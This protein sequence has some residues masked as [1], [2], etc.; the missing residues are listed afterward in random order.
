VE[1]RGPEI[2]FESISF[3]VTSDLELITEDEKRRWNRGGEQ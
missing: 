2:Q 1:A 3:I